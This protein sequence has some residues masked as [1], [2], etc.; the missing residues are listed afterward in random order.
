[1]FWKNPVCGKITMHESK[2]LWAKW[3]YENQRH[4][5]VVIYVLVINKDENSCVGGHGMMSMF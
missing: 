1:M 4:V 5:N 3:G 2:T